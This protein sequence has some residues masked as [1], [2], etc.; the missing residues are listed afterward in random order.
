MKLHVSCDSGGGS[1]EVRI[2]GVCVVQFCGW[3]HAKRGFKAAF[4]IQQVIL[5]A[6]KSASQTT[7]ETQ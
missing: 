7:E 4:N 5:R 2:N 3:H 1:S 6:Q